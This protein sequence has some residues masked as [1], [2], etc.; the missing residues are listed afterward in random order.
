MHWNVAGLAWWSNYVKIIECMN[1]IMVK[2]VFF[3]GD[4]IV[5]NWSV[6]DHDVW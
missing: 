3:L 1:T 6:V 5:P 2:C 4:W